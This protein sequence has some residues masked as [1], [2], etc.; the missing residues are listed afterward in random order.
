MISSPG[1]S[2][3]MDLYPLGILEAECS[4]RHAVDQ[5]ERRCQN[6]DKGFQEREYKVVVITNLSQFL[7][8]SAVV[9]ALLL[10][11]Y[12]LGL[13]RSNTASARRFSTWFF[14]RLGQCFEALAEQ[15]RGLGRSIAANT[16]RFSTWF[17]PRLGQCFRALA[18]NIGA[19]FLGLGRSITANARCFS[20]CFFPMLA[21][22]F[23]AVA[24]YIRVF[25]RGLYECIV[26][27]VTCL[28]DCL[29]ECC[30]EVDWGFVGIMCY[31]V[32]S[33]VSGPLIL[34]IVLLVM[35]L[36]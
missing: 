26:V 9:L 2:E 19:F 25:F 5:M 4:T 20:S 13:T 34:V 7:Y 22:C 10:S 12:P 29:R 15:S 8:Q 17:F 31:L 35:L 33:I 27:V 24:G 14:P 36:R 3:E 28:G 16:Y 23:R 11:H 1:S 18:G 21:R 6:P 32:V 30:S